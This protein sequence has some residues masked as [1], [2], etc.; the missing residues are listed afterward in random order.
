MWRDGRGRASYRV[1]SDI[2]LMIDFWVMYSISAFPGFG[3]RY[4]GED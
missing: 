1:I 2:G 4:G 3:W